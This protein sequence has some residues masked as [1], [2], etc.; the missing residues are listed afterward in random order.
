[1]NELVTRLDAE[2]IVATHQQTMKLFEQSFDALDEAQ[3][4]CA[5]AGQSGKLCH[6]TISLFT[7]SN[8]QEVKAFHNA[9]NLPDRDDYLRTARKLQEHATWRY[10]LERMGVGRLLDAEEKEKLRKQQEYIPERPKH[11][12]MMIDEREMAKGMPP[13]TVDNI[14]ATLENL[15]AN[16]GDMWRRGIANSFSKLD[17][18]FKSHDGWKIGSRIIITRFVESSGSFRYGYRRDMMLDIERVFLILDGIEP[19]EEYGSIVADIEKNRNYLHGPHQS[20][21][22]GDYFKVRIFQNGNAHLWFKNKELVKQVNKLLAEYYGEVLADDHT[23]HEED[24]LENRKLTPARRFGFFPTQP[25]A[26]DKVI[27]E[28]KLRTGMRV[29][30]P[31]AGT[32]CLVLP[33]LELVPNLDIH[34]VDI[35]GR[36]KTEIPSSRIARFIVRD[37]L[38]LSPDELGLFDRIIMNPPFDMQRDIDHVSHAIKFLKPGGRLVSIMSAGVEF[39]ENKKAVAFRKLI[40]SGSPRWGSSFYGLPARSF[41]AVGTNVNTLICTYDKPEVSQ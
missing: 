37:F 41:S 15:A 27:K 36:F 9:I 25:A 31:S 21:H 32:G 11:S 10:V 17:K 38:A 26:A 20:E 7:D 4:K 39:R 40:K 22:E 8:V 1:M 30:E 23:E 35:Q 34:C 18:R 16:S 5:A 33:A 29:L 14:L 6:P 13:L 28:A 19:R 24:P 3:R 12:R 2:G